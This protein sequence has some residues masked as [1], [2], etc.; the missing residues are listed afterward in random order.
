MRKKKRWIDFLLWCRSFVCQMKGNAPW[1]WI[2][3]SIYRLLF[4]NTC[5]NCFKIQINVCTRHNQ[6][7][8]GFPLDGSCPPLSVEDYRFSDVL[9]RPLEITG[10]FERNTSALWT[11]QHFACLN[12][13][14]RC[15]PLHRIWSHRKVSSPKGNDHRG[16]A[17]I[18]FRKQSAH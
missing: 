14:T 16:P 10:K 6:L 12:L 11:S 7:L 9:D 3:D 5:Q 18:S 8:C 2:C 15:K 17:V 1:K 13:V 4:C